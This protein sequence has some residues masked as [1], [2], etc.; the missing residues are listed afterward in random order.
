ML[1]PIGAIFALRAR[2]VDTDENMFIR[3]KINGLESKINVGYTI[4]SIY[5]VNIIQYMAW[6]LLHRK[7]RETGEK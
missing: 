5:F 4:Y 1:F 2:F 7:G 6:I 3:M